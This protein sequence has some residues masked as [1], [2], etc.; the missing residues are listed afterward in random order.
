VCNVVC[1]FDLL[2]NG[3]SSRF[4]HRQS[5]PPVYLSCTYVRPAVPCAIRRVRSTSRARTYALPCR[6]QSD[7]FA[8]SGRASSRGSAGLVPTGPTAATAGWPEVDFPPQLQFRPRRRD[9]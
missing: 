3:P 2:R 1:A 4:A 7:A 5:I 8:L 9:R 6:A